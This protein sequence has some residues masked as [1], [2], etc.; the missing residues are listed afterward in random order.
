MK[1]II[2][3]VLVIIL[4]ACIREYFCDCKIIKGC[5]L[6]RFVK[7]SDSSILEKRTLCRNIYFPNDS[8]YL[9]TIKLIKLKYDTVTINKISYKIIVSDSIY[10]KDSVYNIKANDT[11]R[12]YDSAYTCKCKD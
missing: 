8:A 6:I 10:K 3:L 11:K 9:D 2:Y 5:K 4:S 7:L 12:F 1:K